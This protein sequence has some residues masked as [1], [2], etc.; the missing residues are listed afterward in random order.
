[1]RTFDRS[2]FEIGSWRAWSVRMHE[3][4]KM[5]CATK[6]RRRNRHIVHGSSN[7]DCA[8]VHS[9]YSSSCSVQRDM[10]CL[11]LSLFCGV[12]I[13]KTAMMIRRFATSVLAPTRVDVRLATPA[14]H[15]LL[16][17]TGVVPA[18]TYVPAPITVGE[19]MRQV[20]LTLR[21][22]RIDGWCT[23]LDYVSSSAVSLGGESDEICTPVH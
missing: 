2:G 17:L 15:T 19:C 9:S 6:T 20:C 12:C 13:I 18:T 7:A 8:I 14:H 4:G 1:M 23:Y 16:A 21:Y 5:R 3:R 10:S 22:S 11:G